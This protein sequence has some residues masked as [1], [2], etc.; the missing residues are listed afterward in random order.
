MLYKGQ[1]HYEII[2]E[3]EGITPK[4]ILFKSGWFKLGA[5]FILYSYLALFT[6]FLKM[7]YFFV[8]YTRFV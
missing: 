7:C 3:K 6:E 5:I 4:C 1:S 2:N 8:A